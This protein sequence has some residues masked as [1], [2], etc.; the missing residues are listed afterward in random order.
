MA[1]GLKIKE[2]LS[3]KRTNDTHET[4]IKDGIG[5]IFMISKFLLKSINHQVI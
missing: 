2:L 3:Y 5:I 1:H 4:E